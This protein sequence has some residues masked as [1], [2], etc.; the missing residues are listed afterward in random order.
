MQLD[1]G[2]TWFATQIRTDTV[3]MAIYF[4]SD[5]ALL[6]GNHRDARLKPDDQYSGHANRS[7]RRKAASEP[8]HFVFGR[9]KALE[10]RGD[11]CDCRLIVCCRRVCGIR[12]SPAGRPG[13]PT[14]RPET[15]ERGTRAWPRIGDWGEKTPVRQIIGT[16]DASPSC[17][18]Q[19]RGHGQKGLEPIYAIRSQSTSGCLALSESKPQEGE[20]TVVEKSL[21]N[22]AKHI[23]HRAVLS[24]RP[25]ARDVTIWTKA[26]FLFRRIRVLARHVR[27][28]TRSY[29]TLRFIDSS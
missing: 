12:R 19:S 16:I 18:R 27:F 29:V 21:G 1:N 24:L 26:R 5:D 22:K 11:R 8:F 3:R 23:R 14:D 10:S 9:R 4:S 13:Q 28:L 7:D 25:N 15:G 6:P 20:Y 2:S 17:S